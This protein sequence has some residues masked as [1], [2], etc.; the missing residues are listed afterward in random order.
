MVYWT[1]YRFKKYSLNQELLVYNITFL[2]F[3]KLCP[4]SCLQGAQYVPVLQI[5]VIVGQVLKI[6]NNDSNTIQISL[7]NLFF[8]KIA[9][10][11]LEIL[12][13]H[14]LLTFLLFS[15][16]VRSSNLPH[17]VEIW[18]NDTNIIWSSWK[19]LLFPKVT[20]V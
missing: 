7:K 14:A 1:F 6:S 16:F 13:C 10:A 3:G 17:S 12:A 18:K 20:R 15:L 11:W 2:W 5:E 4:A 9:R 19:N 8:H